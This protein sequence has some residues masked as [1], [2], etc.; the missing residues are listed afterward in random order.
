MRSLKFLSVLIGLLLI[1][2]VAF[3][4]ADIAGIRAVWNQEIFVLINTSSE[5]VNVSNLGFASANGEILPE[6]WV[7]DTVGDNNIPYSLAEFEPGSCLLAFLSGTAP[8]L[9]ATVSCTRVVGEFTV[10]NFGDIVWDVT[11]RGFQCRCRWRYACRMRH[12]SYQL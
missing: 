4:Q 9:P 5:D 10:T 12:Q 6:N 11:Q 3:A 1:S 2:Q 8:D 7:M